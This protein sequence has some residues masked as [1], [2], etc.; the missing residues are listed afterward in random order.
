DADVLAREHDGE[1]ALAYFELCP[2]DEADIKEEVE[3][4]FKLS[5][6]GYQRDVAELSEK[7]GYTLEI[8]P[9]PTGGTGV[10][11]VPGGVPPPG[12]R[13]RGT[14]EQDKANPSRQ[15]VLRA[16]A[17][18]LQPIFQRLESL[19]QTTDPDEFQ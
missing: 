11:P 19:L 13:N 18:S 4:T 14:P 10:P 7:T 1:P 8:K 5:Q 9:Q 17:T 15:K 2:R 16:R 12:L 3:N 6:A